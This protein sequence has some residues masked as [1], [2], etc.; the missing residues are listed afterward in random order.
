M[1][2]SIVGSCV[3]RDQFSLL[4]TKE[5]CELIDYV[6]RQSLVSARYEVDPKLIDKTL[7]ES[8]FQL[9]SEISDFQAD[10]WRR[11]AEFAPNSDLILMDLIDERRGLL[12]L[13]HDQFIT[14]NWELESTKLKDRLNWVRFVEFGSNE[15][16]NQWKL[17][18]LRLLHI[19]EDYDKRHALICIPPLFADK[20]EDG[21]TD[22]ELS[23]VHSLRTQ[24]QRYMDFLVEQGVRMAVVPESRLTAD[25]DHRWGPRPFHYSA[26]SEDLIN[27][28]ILRNWAI[29]NRSEVERTDFEF[30][31]SKASVTLTRE[32]ENGRNIHGVVALEPYSQ[33]YLYVENSDDSMTKPRLT[34]LFNGAVDVKRAGNNPVFQR[35]SWANDIKGDLLFVADPTLTVAAPLR[36]GWGQGTAG[37]WG[38]IS[39]A[40]VIEAALNF[41]RNRRA[42]AP[43]EGEVQL[44]GSSAGGFQALVLGAIVESNRVIVNN[45]QIDWLK[46]EVRGAVRDAIEVA[47]GKIANAPGFRD[48]WQ[49]R[50]SATSL[51]KHNHFCPNIHYYL[52]LDS[53]FDMS[54]QYPVFQ[55]F[56]DD[57]NNQRYI[58]NVSIHYY[59]AAQAGHNPLDKQTTLNI[60]NSDIIDI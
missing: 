39:Q 33:H 47:Y 51:F 50:V 48:R 59:R 13:G 16:F 21:S 6:A 49:T 29:I 17:S 3:S 44:F 35:S 1:K 54:L 36:L 7:F 38:S 32:I 42:L 12:E 11:A 46:Y 58:Q 30:A 40:G 37:H 57:R 34:V 4:Q 41:W 18:V 24:Y 27:R 60:I 15:H 31:C 25:K 5:D 23:E 43:G 52:N 45:P 19:L 53:K 28:A 14:N 20:Y 8:K 56:L 10:L 2:V 22:H 9:N 26:K 55:R